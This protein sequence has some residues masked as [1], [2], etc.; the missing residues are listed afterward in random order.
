MRL[1]EG[2]YLAGLGP[3]FETPAEMGL[4]VAGDL[5]ISNAALPPPMGLAGALLLRG[6]LLLGGATPQPGFYLMTAAWALAA[7]YHVAFEEEKKKPPPQ[8]KGTEAPKPP[9]PPLLTR[10]LR[11]FVSPWVDIKHYGETG[12]IKAGSA[13]LKPFL[14]GMLTFDS[15][16]KLVGFLLLLHFNGVFYGCLGFVAFQAALMVG[17]MGGI[18]VGLL[19][20]ALSYL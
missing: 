16:F 20:T 14:F 13:K 4:I 12:G 5:L 15:L 7:A 11:S 17:P 19:G 10:M 3:S 9:K 1:S 6:G 2:V 8:E 18:A